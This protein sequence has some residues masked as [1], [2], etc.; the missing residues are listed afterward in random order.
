MKSMSLKK[1]SLPLIFFFFTFIN[2]SSQKTVSLYAGYPYNFAKNIIGI[3][4]FGIE[5]SIFSPR[6]LN[7]R[8]I[9]IRGSFSLLEYDNEQ[10]N[11][12][13]IGLNRAKLFA[14]SPEITISYYYG[15]QY[16][17]NWKNNNGFNAGTL[18]IGSKFLA[19]KTVQPYLQFEYKLS[20][21][22]QSPILNLGLYI[23]I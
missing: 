8:A 18:F 5:K 23:E 21:N 10:F 15:L 17:Y 20:K 4:E 2:I 11:C 3:V 14:L 7:D 22:Y 1:I 12:I 13:N 6:N 16:S 9:S 19:N